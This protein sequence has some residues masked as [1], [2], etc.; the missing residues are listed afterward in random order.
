MMPD[1]AAFRAGQLEFAELVRDL[2]YRA[3]SSLADQIYNDLESTTA[4]ATDAAVAFVPQDPNLQAPG[5]EGWTLGHVIVHLTAG[6]EELSA[7]AAMMARGV[8]VEGRLRYELPWESVTT[9]GQ[10]R[11]RLQESR[12]ICKAFLGG[13]PDEPHLDLTRVMVPRFGPLNAVGIFTI[14]L[15]HADGHFEQ[16]REIMRQSKDLEPA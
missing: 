6:L 7:I 8:P 15:M 5:E 16:L 9:T 10:I 11:L 3:L 14:G 2:D 4:D 12:R 1:F 13:W